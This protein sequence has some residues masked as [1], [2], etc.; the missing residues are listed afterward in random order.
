MG[1]DEPAWSAP[2]SGDA[3][4]LGTIERQLAVLSLELLASTSLARQ[5]T[6]DGFVDSLNDEAGIQT[7]TNATYDSTNDLYYPVLTAATYGSDFCTGGTATSSTQWAGMPPSQAFD[8]NA[9]VRFALASGYSTG[10]L[11]Y[12]LGAGVTKIARKITLQ[13][14]LNQC[15][16]NWSLDGSNNDST[17][18]NIA[19]GT[20]GNNNDVETWYFANSTAYRY[21]R[22]N[23]DSS[24]GNGINVSEMELMEC[25]AEAYYNNVT[26]ES[27]TC[28]ADA[29]PGNAQALFL[30]NP[31]QALTLN[32][33]IKGYVSR[34]GGTNYTE[35]TLALKETFGSGLL[36]YGSD[37]AI[38]T[39]SGTNMRIKLTSHNNKDFD[40]YGWALL[41][42]A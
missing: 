13:S 2:A 36:L 9:S 31:I 30:V 24:I 39:T 6:D 14:Y 21:Y 18:T 41:W 28:A 19:S 25:T 17:W 26:L 29:A 35:F 40:F 32:T 4:R 7:K 1:A 27:T 22:L 42:R 37:E 33:D 3:T 15:V 23:I 5:E 12:D 8:N 34:N 20:H 11:K 16:L 10:W 38:T